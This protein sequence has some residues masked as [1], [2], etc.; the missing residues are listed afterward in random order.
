GWVQNGRILR[1]LK[2]KK[3]FYWPK[4][5]KRGTT[6][7]RWKDLL[8]GQGPDIHI[9]ISGEKRTR[10]WDGPSR[11]R[12][13]RWTED[14][15][16]APW[17]TEQPLPSPFWARRKAHEKY[18]FRTRKFTKRNPDPSCWTDVRWQY[19]PNDHFRDPYAFRDLD[20]RWWQD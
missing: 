1:G 6:W 14:A 19:P 11:A 2:P 7:G 9:R 17:E 8:S 15:F 10:P 4:D 3:A 16:V 5:G 18:D 12:W 20:G 13:S